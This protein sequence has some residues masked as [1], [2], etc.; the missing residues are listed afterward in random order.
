MP[1]LQLSVLL[2]LILATGAARD[3][4]DPNDFQKQDASVTSAKDRANE[5]A[6]PPRRPPHLSKPRIPPVEKEHWTPE[7]KAILEPLERQRRLYNV[8]STMANHP[9]L[10]RDWLT[11]AN[12]VL[13]KCTLAPRD[14]EILI[15]RI[16]WLCGA[17]YEWAQHV[18]IG[19]AVGLTDDDLRHIQQGP[20]A[21]GASHHDRLLLKAVDELHADAFIGDETWNALAET[22]D[23][24]QMMD[25][26]FA[27][28]Q[29]NL[30]SMALN[31]FGVQLDPGL[32]GFSK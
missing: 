29:Y 13:R 2:A 7:Q 12:H 6:G 15:L 11:F 24:R 8:F 20:Q 25:L 18:R 30:V 19:K 1:R 16:G 3:A 21:A 28:G 4:F 31:S 14:R 10:A 9:D 5:P 32:E 27:V 23:T 22:Y 26:V 17:E